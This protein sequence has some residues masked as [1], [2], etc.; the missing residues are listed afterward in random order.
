M[1][2]AGRDTGLSLES[3][4][5]GAEQVSIG[6]RIWQAAR[7]GRSLAT[8]N[9]EHKTTAKTNVLEFKRPVARPALALL[10]A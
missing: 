3:L 10:A 7:R 5:T 4:K 2:E 1:G 8:L 6:M 9:T